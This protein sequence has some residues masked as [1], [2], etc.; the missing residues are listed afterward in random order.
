MAI[1]Y[2]CTKGIELREISIQVRSWR[3]VNDIRININL[4]RKEQ[5]KHT[6][7]YKVIKS[8]LN[9]KSKFLSSNLWPFQLDSDV[10]ALNKLLQLLFSFLSFSLSLSLVS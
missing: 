8:Q 5:L 1:D 9:M 2:K 10:D 7:Y 3:D 4:L 6:R